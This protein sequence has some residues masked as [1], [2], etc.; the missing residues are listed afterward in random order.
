MKTK[1]IKIA[2]IIEILLGLAIAGLGVLVFLVYGARSGGTTILGWMSRGSIILLGILLV[3]FGINLLRLKKW[4]WIASVIILLIPIV[5]FSAWGRTYLFLCSIGAIICLVLL[6]WGVREIFLTKK[7]IESLQ[8]IQ[9][10]KRVS[11]PWKKLKFLKPSFAK[12][13]ITIILTLPIVLAW[14]T[15]TGERTPALMIAIPSVYIAYPV[16]LLFSIL[17]KINIMISPEHPLLEPI[18]IIIL[19]LYYYIFA[20][21]VVFIY[22]KISSKTGGGHKRKY[23][24]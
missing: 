20:C 23:F 6:I 10:E 13:F 1:Y 15:A 14:L 19:A 24:K 5:F 2:S 21:L 8:K 17:Q 16:L 11:A 3:I 18:T 9:I 12:I 22:K 4:A 7:E